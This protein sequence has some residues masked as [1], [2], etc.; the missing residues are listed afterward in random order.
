MMHV[1]VTGASSG[2]GE[3]IAREYARAGAKVTLVARR[4]E[5]L[6]AI[7]KDIEGE[8]VTRDLSDPAQACDWIAPAEEKL[9]PIDVLVNNAGMQNSG[10]TADSDVDEGT[11]LLRL[12]LFAPLLATRA[13]L[14][15]MLAR[16]SGTII[17]V[18]STAAL[19]PPPGLAWYGASKAGLA[20]FSEALRGELRG[21]PVHV[22]TV[23]PGPVDTAM[24][25]AAYQVYGGKKGLVGLLPEGDAD[26]LAR[27]VRRAAE[28]RRSRVVYPRFYAFARYFPWLGRWLTDLGAPKLQSRTTAAPQ[29]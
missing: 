25:R 2:I 15:K 9:G 20:A 24:A 7:A 16:G 27:I 4:K 18:T 28:K 8:V 1:A 22:L 17:D 21:S 10:S 29:V 5:L 12:N 6:D 19:V 14:P 23:Y 26:E 3:A 13:V 11:R